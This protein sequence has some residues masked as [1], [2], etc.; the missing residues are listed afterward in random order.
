M[1]NHPVNLGYEREWE[2]RR[3]LQQ[4]AMLPITESP[5]VESD[6]PTNISVDLRE[7]Q[8]NPDFYV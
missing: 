5:T 2:R 8:R 7:P 6:G 4:A 3:D 1:A